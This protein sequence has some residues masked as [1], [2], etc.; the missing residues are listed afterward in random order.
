MAVSATDGSY[1]IPNRVSLGVNGVTSPLPRSHGIKN[2][3]LSSPVL[4]TRTGTPGAAAP[5]PR[6]R[7]VS[8]TIKP[9]FGA[10][11][12]GQASPKRIPAPTTRPFS[13]T[14]SARTTST[15]MNPA[16]PLPRDSMVESPTK[17]LPSR[18]MGFVSLQSQPSV[19]ARGGSVNMGGVAS[20]ATL[21]AASAL[22]LQGECEEAER[23]NAELERR[24]DEDGKNFLDAL[25]TLE[26]EKEDLTKQN[27]QLTTE[28]AEIED[29]LRQ[30][31]SESELRA[32]GSKLERD[33]QDLMEMMDAF[34]QE[35]D[36]ELEQVREEVETAKLKLADKERGLERRLAELQRER[37]NIIEN[38]TEDGRELES[39]LEKLTRDKETLSQQLAKAL[40][41]TDVN[42][43]GNDGLNVSPPA[44]VQ[45]LRSVTSERERLKDEVADKEGH[46][47]LFQ[48]QLV[49]FDRKLRLADM[50]N[51]MLKSELESL[52][53]GSNGE[54]VGSPGA[55]DVTKPS[56]VG[57][58]L[59]RSGSSTI[60]QN[61]FG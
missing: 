57:G 36:E 53:R 54:A 1:L 12:V 6:I 27:Q 58:S 30:Q 51:S 56:G 42:A 35:K 24:L 3:G 22:A 32:K 10:P 46:I 50:E 31:E 44:A 20:R 55:A 40:A 7:A 9:L 21:D 14:P 47:V 59:W 34:E 38:F 48:S 11:L 52:R 17:M 13:Q 23:V 49:M 29:Q 39:R 15:R 41:Q 61:H 45:E 43:H 26:M 37:N 28:R 4:P 60:S 33:L 18:S 2:V 25:V 5:V 19:A 8:P 16:S